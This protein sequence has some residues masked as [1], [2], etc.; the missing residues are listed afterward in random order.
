MAAEDK[1]QE[2][3]KQLVAETSDVAN[4]VLD[5]TDAVMLSGETAAGKYPMEAVN[6]MDRI[7]RK[8]EKRRIQLYYSL[9]YNK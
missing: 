6:V 9:E 4:A 7:C 5:G 1:R 2:I 3:Q 8:I